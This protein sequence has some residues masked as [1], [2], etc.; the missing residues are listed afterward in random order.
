MVPINRGQGLRRLIKSN[1]IKNFINVSK[2][3]AYRLIGL[4]Q[5][6]PVFAWSYESSFAY[7]SLEFKLVER[8][9][10]DR[11]SMCMEQ[12]L[13]HVAIDLGVSNVAQV[14]EFNPVDF[15]ND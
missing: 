7:V 9:G 12:N 13:R 8:T 14:A 5:F 6:V 2:Y 3:F 4:L 1:Q 11:I 10:L 15:S